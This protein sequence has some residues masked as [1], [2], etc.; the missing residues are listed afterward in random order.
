V[1]FIPPMRKLLI[2]LYLVTF[3][4]WSK[5]SSINPLIELTPTFREYVSQL[6][7][8]PNI[9]INQLSGQQ[10]AF[11]APIDKAQQH[12]LLSLA[13]NKQVHPKEALFHADAGLALLEQQ[14]QPWLVHYLK[15]T[16]GVA[17]D[18]SGNPDVSVKL[19]SEA[20]EWAETN[21]HTSLL[22][23]AL[24]ARSLAFNTLRSPVEAL[25]DAQRAYSMAP[26]DHPQIAKAQIAANI[27]LVYEYRRQPERALPY[28]E[29]AVNYHRKHERWRDLGDVLYGLGQAN[30]LIKNTKIGMR[31]LEESIQVARKVDDIQ[32]VAYGLKQLAGL[33]FKEK[34]FD[35][36][37]SMFKEALSIFEQSGNAYTRSDC[38]MWLARIA[39]ERQQPQVAFA[40]LAR[41]ELLINKKSMPGHYFRLQEQMSETYKAVGDLERA[42]AILKENYPNRLQMLKKQ[43]I[44]EFE[45]LKNEFELNKLDNENQLLEKD[46]LLKTS[47]LESQIKKNQY[48]YLLV[49]LTLVICILLIFILHKARQSKRKFEQLSM[50]DDLTKLA[51]RR[52]VFQ[53]LN[54][55]IALSSRHNEDLTVAVID[56]DFFKNINDEYGH[57]MG[58]HVLVE[59]AKLCQST[60][61]KTDLIGRIGGEEFLVALPKTNVEGATLIL[62]KLKEATVLLPKTSTQL[63][64]LNSEDSKLSISIGITQLMKSDSRD[65]IFT[66]ADEALYK[67]KENGRNQIQ[68][69]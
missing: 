55:Q 61:R 50:I 35:K 31:Q 15:I 53:M 4:G 57:T 63:A 47:I 39:V 49:T 52:N 69:A 67:A 11:T 66:R 44:N 64:P 7:V 34:N 59:F 38:I 17:L 33:E 43:Y 6:G 56:L 41:A 60:L 24:M 42:Y 45:E 30:I 3:V 12:L 27:A 1:L 32:G 2:V 46:N 68:A 13:Y 65:K 48:L 18:L 62:N 19:A 58:D 8:N 5:A 20:L 29:E 23:K 28:F 9:V 40:Y 21:N 37:E 22:I 26:I 14:S 54:R 10:P 25:R 51:N 36:A 16:K